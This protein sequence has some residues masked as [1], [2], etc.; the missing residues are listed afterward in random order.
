MG[1]WG[2]QGRGGMV[3]TCATNRP[4]AASRIGARPLWVCSLLVLLLLGG[5][6]LPDTRGS[7]W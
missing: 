1:D 4:S 7:N 3:P 6:P 2:C 5:A